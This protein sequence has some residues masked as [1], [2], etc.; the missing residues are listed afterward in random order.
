M[1][2]RPARRVAS[3]TLTVAHVDPA[4]VVGAYGPVHL[5]VYRDAL[6]SEG[7]EIANSHHRALMSR[8]PRTFVL[9]AAQS[10]LPLPPSDVRQRGAELIDENQAHVEAA[11][12]VLQG[13]GFWASAVRS[14]MTASFAIARQPY[15]SKAFATGA[16]AAA[17]LTSFAAGAVLDPVGVAEALATLERT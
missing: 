7:L 14:V 4:L 10:N 1:S 13:T 8:F 15:P 5:C 12:M 2:Q 11:A 16:E 3:A 6:T 9:G 17:W